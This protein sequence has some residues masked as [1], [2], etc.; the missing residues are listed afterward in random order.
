MDPG[1]TAATQLAFAQQD[2]LLLIDEAAGRRLASRLG[3]ANTGTLGVLVA[4]AREGKIDLSASLF[5]LQQTNFR[6]SQAFIE[7]L[8]AESRRPYL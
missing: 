6:M 7:K 8:F 3:V 1:E 2:R 4:G 5:R